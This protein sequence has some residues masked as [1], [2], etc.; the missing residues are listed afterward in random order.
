VA[1]LVGLL[2]FHSKANWL[3]VTVVT[4]AAPFAFEKIVL[5]GGTIT[6][7]S[8]G[9]VSFTPVMLD[10]TAWYQISGVALFVVL[11]ASVVFVS[12]DMGTVLRAIRDN[13]RRCRYLGIPVQTIKMLLFIAVAVVVS[14]AGAIYAFSQNVVAPDVGSFQLATAMVIWTAVGGRGTLFGPAIAAVLVNWATAYLGG[15]FPFVWQLGLGVVFVVVVLYLPR[16][17]IAL[18]LRPLAKFRNVVSAGSDY[19]KAVQLV[20]EPSGAARSEPT[21]TALEVDRVSLRYGTLAAVTN[22]SFHGLQGELLSIVGPNGA[23]KTSLMRCI[24]DGMQRTAGAV[25]VNGV[26]LDRHPPEVVSKLGVGQKFQKASV[27][28]TLSIAESITIARYRLRRPS[29]WGRA[30][31]LG[32]PRPVIDILEATGIAG[33]LGTS[34]ANLSHGEKQALELAMVLCTEPEVILMDE[35]TAGLS[36]TERTMIGQVFQKLVSDHNRLVI[37]IEHDLD[38]VQKISTRVIV[39]HEGKLLLDG[40]VSEIVASSLVKEIYTGTKETVSQ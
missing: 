8:T 20:E 14:V 30:D 27:F 5:S 18:L 25:R 13:E 38:F 23:G 4:F 17:A 3:Y 36:H 21:S 34:V 26:D 32:V 33:E 19:E 22:V 39:M 7:A 40:S 35:P 6:G 28:P 29:L 37:L 1:V 10:I 12:S 11:A 16:G 2:S 31:S 15:Q 9:L 24:S